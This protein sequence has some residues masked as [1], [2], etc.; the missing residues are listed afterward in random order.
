[1]PYSLR[2]QH[3]REATPELEPALTNDRQKTVARYSGQ[4]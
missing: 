2:A 4:R 3:D 1:M